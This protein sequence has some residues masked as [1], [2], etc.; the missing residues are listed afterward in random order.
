MYKLANLLCKILNKRVSCRQHSTGIFLKKSNTNR[1]EEV[2]SILP[3]PTELQT[4]SSKE[5]SVFCRSSALQGTTA[6]HRDV[7]TWYTLCNSEIIAV[8]SKTRVTCWKRYLCL[9]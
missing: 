2:I 6:S 1:R 4:F 7:L 9:E 3:Q 5:H 8:L